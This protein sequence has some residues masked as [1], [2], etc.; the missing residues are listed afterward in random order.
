[1]K[2]EYFRGEMF[3]IS[4]ASYRHNLIAANII[5]ELGSRLRGQ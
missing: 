3:A 2:S 5:G 4:G 1:M